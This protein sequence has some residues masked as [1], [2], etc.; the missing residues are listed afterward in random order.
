MIIDAIVR[1][2]S[3][4]VAFFLQ[5]LPH[6]PTEPAAALSAALVTFQSWWVGLVTPWEYY[7]PLDLWM[8][9]GAAFILAYG[10][11]TLWSGIAWIIGVVRGVNLG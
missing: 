7:L 11:Y 4:M 10:A 5:F 1:A 9:L 6:I 3:G 2:L 8:H